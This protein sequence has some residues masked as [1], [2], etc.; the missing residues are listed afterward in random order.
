M[1]EAG[2][3]LLNTVSA[4]KWK[5]IGVSRRAGILVPLFSV[6][7]R[8]SL[9]IGE[10]AD[11]KLLS[12]FC[13]K[14]GASIIQF[15]PMNEIGSTFCPYDAVS[16]F[17][18][19]PSYI[20]LSS[21]PGPI[22][23]KKTVKAAIR[24][25]REAFPYGAGYVDYAIKDAKREILWAAYLEDD[26]ASSA[27]FKKF[28]DS[29]RYWIND[30]ALYKALK[31][32]H[33]GKPWYEWPEEYK[34]RDPKALA[35][36]G[37]KYHK[38]VG[39]QKW[40]QYAAFTQFSAA[41]KHAAS[42]GVLF[43]GDLPILISRDS[44]DVW[45]HPEFFKL[46][47]L[48]G[49]PPDMYCAKGQRWGMPTYDWDAIAA[50]KFRY[51]REKLRYAEN[52][53]DIIRVDHVVGLFRIWSIPCGDPAENEGLNGAFD[54]SD[55]S[56]WGEHGRRLLSVMLENTDM[57]LCAEDLGIIPKDCPITL[58]EF[59]IPGNDVQRWVK[60][61]AKKHDFLPP[62][63]YRKLS[64]AMLS[65]H[66]TTNW[67]AWW[68]N[69]AGTVD[70]PLFMRK[71]RERGIDFDAVRD[72]LFDAGRSRHGRLRWNDS[73]GS[74][75]EYVRIL[76]RREEE[77]MDFI[78]LYENS[79]REKEKLWARL[80][81]KGGMRELS[82]AGIV[83][84]A[85]GITMSSS[86]IF[87]IELITDYLYT[88]GIFKGDPYQYRINKPGTVARTN[89]SLRMPLSLEEL[90]GHGLCGELKGLI[91]SSCRAR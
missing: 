63:E 19:E 89:W 87:C 61:W 7:S 77:L 47:F 44:A 42:K 36:F 46:D 90:L 53:Y 78:D 73:V 23:G 67:A 33:A 32:H 82:D 91:S 62:E 34:C 4:D 57:L 9:G 84:A 37:R 26:G 25:A 29:N 28:I 80:G 30:F 71:C 3:D 10:M 59:G 69:E 17:A 20:S 48:A 58:K 1:K 21:L 11:L 2:S 52:F 88:A 8:D 13:G 81:L 86:S 75:E 49:A 60:D 76:G 51:V 43:K 50:D 55:E 79:Y 12:D 39:F 22:S 27:G 5:R 65:T 38:E 31:S 83:R 68:E 41:R 40:M 15:L 14:T 74:K 18:L 35:D 66:D 72:R 56:V 16:S 6:Y 64:V 24:K 54:P 45:S 85:L 70:G